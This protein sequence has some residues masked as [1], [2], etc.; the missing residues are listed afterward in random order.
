MI[1]QIHMTTQLYAIFFSHDVSGQI[2]SNEDD[3][4]LF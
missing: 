1:P 2:N 3:D 4:T